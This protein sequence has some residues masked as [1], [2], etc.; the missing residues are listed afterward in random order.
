MALGPQAVHPRVVWENKLIT[1]GLP[2]D[3]QARAKRVRPSHPHSYSKSKDHT[4]TVPDSFQGQS[5]S[6]SLQLSCPLCV[7]LLPASP[8]SPLLPSDPFPGL[9]CIPLPESP[10]LDGPGAWLSLERSWSPVSRVSRSGGD[11]RAAHG[12]SRLQ[13]RAPA[14]L[15]P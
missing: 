2:L 13:G 14:E 9:S 8:P 4:V 7:C 5:R 15:T 3:S 1:E 10:S 11:A 12:G 6:L